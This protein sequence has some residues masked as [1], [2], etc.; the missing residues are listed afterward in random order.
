MSASGDT[1]FNDADWLKRLE[2]KDEEINDLLGEITNLRTEIK[3]LG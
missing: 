3:R 1:H 2:R